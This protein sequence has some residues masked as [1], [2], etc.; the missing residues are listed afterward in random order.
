MDTRRL[1]KSVMLITIVCVICIGTALATN[2]GLFKRQ[3]PMTLDGYHTELSQAER[4]AL[5]NMWRAAKVPTAC[6]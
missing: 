4:L 6:F 3:I 5:C 2:T 1:M